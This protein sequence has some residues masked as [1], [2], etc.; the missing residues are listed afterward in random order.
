MSI[1]PQ[2][3]AVLSPYET[4]LAAM[5]AVSACTLIGATV[6]ASN[7]FSGLPATSPTPLVKDQA[8]IQ[9]KSSA[10]SGFLV[11]PGPISTM[12]NAQGTLDLTNPLVTELISAILAVLGDTAGNQ[13]TSVV[14]ALAR[15]VQQ[16][17]GSVNY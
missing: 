2:G 11:V 5:Q 17:T 9:V 6:Q 3:T 10:G 7:S 14:G 4:L 16:G 15:Q 13:W 8:R 12:F 1:Y